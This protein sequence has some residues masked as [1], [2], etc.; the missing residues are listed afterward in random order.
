M[1]RLK[2]FFGAVGLLAFAIVFVG[3]GSQ[4]EAKKDLNKRLR[5]DYDL[6]LIGV[7]AVDGLGFDPVTLRRQADGVSINAALR[8][9][10]HF[11][12]DGTGTFVHER[13][14]NI[15][16]Q[17][18]VGDFSLIQ[19]EGTCDVG[20]NVNADGSFS[21]RMSCVSTLLKGQAGPSPSFPQTLTEPEFQLDGR[22]G[23]QGNV[24]ILGGTNPVVE[25]VTFSP[26]PLHLKRICGR[27]GTAV[28]VTTK[29][30][31]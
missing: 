13:L 1:R 5:G 28:R 23:P 21:Q 8:G 10:L 20:Y 6:S 15:T 3:V 31:D 17:N 29:D 26:P 27:S 7:C 2:P 14:R 30:E 16:N 4:V 12:G 9:I 11:N 19:A 18:A 24:L 25:E 22:I